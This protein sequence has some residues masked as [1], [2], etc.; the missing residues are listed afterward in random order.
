MILLL[1]GTG[2]GRMLGQ[3]LRAAGLPFVASVTTPEARALF[4]EIDPPPEVVVTRF[5]VGTLATFLHER[6]IG[7]IL[8]ATHPFAHRISETAMQ[9]AAQVDIP[10][11]RYE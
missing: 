11:V 4:A 5:S 2:E 3:R 6:R 9:A 8:D 10:Y 1:S 7:A